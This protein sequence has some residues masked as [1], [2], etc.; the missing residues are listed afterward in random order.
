MRYGSVCS[1][2]EAATVKDCTRCK[3]VKPLEDF[4]RHHRSKL[5]RHSWCKAC[6]YVARGPRKAL[7]IEVARERNLSRRYGLTAEGAAAML[8]SQGG[9]CAICK[10]VPQKACVDHDHG[11]GRVRGILCHACNIKLPAVENESYLAG[12]LVYLNGGA[13]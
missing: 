8:H 7:P 2:I 13:A 6:W 4:H 10:T 9:V 1:G 11:T 5:G 3:S 12:A